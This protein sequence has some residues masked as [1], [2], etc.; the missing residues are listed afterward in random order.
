MYTTYNENGTMNNYAIETEMY[1][2]QYPSPE[3]MRSYLIQGACATALI[4]STLL[5]AFIAS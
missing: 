1:A 2:A 5:I 4:L 3:Q